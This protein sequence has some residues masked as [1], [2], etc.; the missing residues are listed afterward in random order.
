MIRA[1]V[2]QPQDTVTA[3]VNHVAESPG[4][5]LSQDADRQA[6]YE[7]QSE[8]TPASSGP[9]ERSR[10]QQPR[11]RS[12]RIITPMKNAHATETKHSFGLRSLEKKETTQNQGIAEEHVEWHAFNHKS[13]GGSWA[14]KEVEDEDPP[15]K[16]RGRSS[17]KTVSQQEPTPSPSVDIPFTEL[18]SSVS[19][20]ALERNRA[21]LPSSSVP[22]YPSHSQGPDGDL[23]PTM[24][25]RQ[26]LSNHPI[27]TVEPFR[28]TTSSSSFSGNGLGKYAGNDDASDGYRSPNLQRDQELKVVTLKEFLGLSVI[29]LSSIYEHCHSEV[30]L[31]MEE[32]KTSMPVA[33][34]DKPTLWQAFSKHSLEMMQ[35]LMPSPFSSDKMEK[36]VQEN[37]CLLSEPTLERLR[38]EIVKPP[39]TSGYK[40]HRLHYY[41][42]IEDFAKEL[43]KDRR[44]SMARWTRAVEDLERLL[45]ETIQP[46]IES[47]E[48]CRHSTST[49]IEK[50]R[51][52]REKPMQGRAF[53]P[54]LREEA[55]FTISRYDSIDFF[56]TLL[57]DGFAAQ[58]KHLSKLLKEDM[59]DLGDNAKGRFQETFVVAVERHF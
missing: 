52:E 3:N 25:A 15:P 7:G 10:I 12:K 47:L 11:R 9:D 23:A 17:R 37:P 31:L 18:T 54:D 4:R 21:F 28:P 16:A 46:A 29:D 55:K 30:Q 32:V 42:V 35:I 53:K 26:K 2:N 6:A 24:H 20:S 43:T 51:A 13:K 34:D 36:L 40:L 8:R 33:T 1:N 45:R 5:Q 56:S 38:E 22:V 48:K 14:W 39:I 27:V 58:I 41:Q 57:K 19:A 50:R 49:R 59:A 44:K